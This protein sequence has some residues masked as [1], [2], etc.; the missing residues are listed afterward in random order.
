MPTKPHD[1]DVMPNVR[2]GNLWHTQNQS[3]LELEYVKN[4]DENSN[5]LFD[6]ALSL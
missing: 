4:F 6:V 2:G 5:P 3:T 1:R